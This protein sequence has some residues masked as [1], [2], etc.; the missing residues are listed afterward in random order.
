[1][2]GFRTAACQAAVC[3]AMSRH[4]ANAIGSAIL[5]RLIGSNRGFRD[6]NALRLRFG[7]LT[8]A[9]IGAAWQAAVLGVAVREPA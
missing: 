2:R 4:E 8:G 7:G 3:Q 9:R 5:G 1:M 6:K